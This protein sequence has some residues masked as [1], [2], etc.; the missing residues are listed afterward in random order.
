MS[1]KLTM[2]SGRAHSDGKTFDPKHNDRKFN[3]AHA[4]N[5]IMSKLKHE[6]YWNCVDKKFYGY[7]DKGYTSF[8][9]AEL[10][11]YKE[12]YGHQL[13]ETNAKYVKNR[14]PEKVKSMEEWM[15]L[16]QN[17]PEEC[18]VQ[19]GDSFGHPD[20]ETFHECF[21]EWL[22]WQ[23]EWN[24]SHGNPFTILDVA[25]H[26]AE[27]VPQAHIRRVWSYVDENGNRRL[28][29][30]KALAMAGV[31]LPE[32]YIHDIEG[33]LILGEDNKPLTS[34]PKRYNNRK[35]TFD[36]LAREKWIEI[37]RS[38][39]IEIEDTPRIDVQHNLDKR[40]AIVQQL[41]VAEQDT[42]KE[43]ERTEILKSQNTTLSLENEGL[44]LDSDLMKE[45]TE[46]LTSEQT[47][48]IQVNSSL[49]QEKTIL[50]SQLLELDDK[51]KQKEQELDVLSSR[52]MNFQGMLSNRMDWEDKMKQFD[53][54][55][56]RMHEAPDY[57]ITFLK[58]LGNKK[59]RSKDGSI[60]EVPYYDMY[61]HSLKRHKQHLSLMK[62]SYQDEAD[63][64]YN[65]M[66]STSNKDTHNFVD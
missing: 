61:R 64:F 60:K 57:F 53:E 20:M 41:R 28:G 40:K 2:H 23:N 12:N 7:Y 62:E 46:R 43:M 36:S 56:K 15:Y 48:L 49:K 26:F 17:A 30:E 50:Q 34:I 55:L 22:T 18:Y 9:D 21:T 33:N 59:Y 37:V 1:N 63:T 32:Q 54:L 31:E 6:R 66:D 24:D 16:R 8:A 47:S 52:I 13:A 58:S 19:I 42:Q 39:D 45:E 10:Q 38:H 29:Q 11:H 25:E 65:S 14:H 51:K 4:N 5:I 3:I 44:T 35:M 27:E